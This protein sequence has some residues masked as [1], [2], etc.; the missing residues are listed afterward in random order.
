LLHTDDGLRIYG[1]GILSSGGEVVYCIESPRPRRLEFDLERVM[2]T[3]YRIDRVQDTYFV[4]ESFERLVED[5]APDFAPIYDR[6]RRLR[7][8]APDEALPQDTIADAL[9]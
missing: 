4:I 1:A 3:D 8:I 6:L 2:R 5:T 9:G 7:A